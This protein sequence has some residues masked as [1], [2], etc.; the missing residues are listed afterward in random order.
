MTDIFSN[1]ELK[2]CKFSNFKCKFGDFLVKNEPKSL[3][4]SCHNFFYGSQWHDLHFLAL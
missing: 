1:L 2:K 3:Q 4:T